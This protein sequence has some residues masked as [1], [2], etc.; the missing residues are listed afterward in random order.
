[1]KGIVFTEFLE[2]VESKFGLETVDHI[3]YN[4]NLKSNAIYTAVGTYDYNEMTALLISLSDKTDI[5][6]NGLLYAYGVYFFGMLEKK[7]PYIFQMYKSPL[8][9]LSAIE[10][11]I[12]THVRKIYPDAELPVF[13]IV[14]KTATGITMI[15]KSERGLY[16][17]AK[18]LIEKTFDHYR[19]SSSVK[20][21]L[22]DSR[23]KMVKFELSLD[24]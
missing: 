12:H 20:Y 6:V 11:H 13:D 15:Y 18:A 17:F 2:M 21:E 14:N 19:K 5:A 9:F 16:M 23:G 3:I 22:L 4:S 10:S 1:M 7:H 24:E 8:D